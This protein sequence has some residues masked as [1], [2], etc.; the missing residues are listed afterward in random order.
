M[1]KIVPRRYPLQKVEVLI[2]WKSSRIYTYICGDT[3]M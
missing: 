1:H 2:V 3:L